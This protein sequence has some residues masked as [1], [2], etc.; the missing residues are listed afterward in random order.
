MWG[1]FVVTGRYRLFVRYQSNQV[2]FFYSN[3]ERLHPEVR[4][5]HASP[6]RFFVLPTVSIADELAFAFVHDFPSLVRADRRQKLISVPTVY[7]EVG[8]VTYFHRGR[9]SCKRGHLAQVNSNF[10][11]PG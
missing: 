7:Q 8:S 10:L 9:E 6:F 11:R 1:R 4:A 5:V 3:Q 2:A